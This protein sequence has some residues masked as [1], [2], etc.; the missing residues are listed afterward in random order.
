MIKF[1]GPIAFFDVDDTLVS[2]KC[3]PKRS[4][5]SI[6]F[7]DPTGT[8]YL[9]SIQEHI[10]AMKLHK[11]R[12]HTIIVWSAGGEDWAEEV[13]KKLG[14][15]EYVNA[16][17]PKPDWFYDDLPAAE[18]MPEVNRKYFYK[19]TTVELEDES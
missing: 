12:G 14:L 11:L 2:W 15:E 7:N 17:M 13:V 19:G 9:N 4:K 10:D 1:K 6:G 5:N 3:Y 18:F 16:V 8:T